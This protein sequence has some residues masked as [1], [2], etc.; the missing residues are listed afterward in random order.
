MSP[1][2]IVLG[3]LLAGGFIVLSP[4]FG[5][6]GLTV[7]AEIKGFW[8]TQQGFIVMPQGGIVL[9]EDLKRNGLPATDCL[10]YR[11]AGLIS[12]GPTE[13]EHQS[14][15]LY[16][17]AT[18]A[19]DPAV[20]ELLMPSEYG[21]ACIGAVWSKIDEGDGCNGYNT[22]ELLCSTGSGQLR[23]VA[24]TRNCQLYDNVVFRDWCHTERTRIL[25][26]VDECDQISLIQRRRDEC[27]HVLAFKEQQIGL[28]ASIVS[29][30]KKMLCET[31]IHMRQKYPQLF[32]V[33]SPL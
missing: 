8:L 9:A 6:L 14:N 5:L 33:F 12:L 1:S 32:N 27:L 22:G 16:V 3:L 29:S 7:Y 11:Q 15:C 28:C 30:E 10:K 13:G 23:S 21:M 2:R 25:A 19:H 24:Q 20:C 26:G 17:F 31:R 18:L 4:F